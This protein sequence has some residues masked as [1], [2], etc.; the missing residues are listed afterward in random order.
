MRDILLDKW[1]PHLDLPQQELVELAIQLYEREL[2][3]EAPLS[4]Y[5]FV[6]FPMAKAYEGFL[7]QYL[8]D[9]HLISQTTFESRRFRIGRALNPDVHENQRDD[10]WLYDNIVHMCDKEIA[11]ALWNTWLNCRNRIFHYF[12]KDHSTVTLPEAEKDLRLIATTMGEAVHCQIHQLE[13]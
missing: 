5:S 3:S 12:P 7:K 9:L 10:A 4:D 6:V 1:F 11:S 2:I 8:Y 13:L